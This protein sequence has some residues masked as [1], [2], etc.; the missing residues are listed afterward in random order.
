MQSLASALGRAVH[1]PGSLLAARRLEADPRA[2]FRPGAA[3]MLTLF[4]A[5]FAIVLTSSFDLRE[6]RKDR[7]DASASGVPESGGPDLFV[8]GSSSL[9]GPEGTRPA[10]V[11]QLANVRGVAEA[12]PVYASVYGDAIRDPSH[13]EVTVRFRQR[14]VVADCVDFARAVRAPAEDCRTGVLMANRTPPGL[15]LTLTFRAPDGQEF[16][17]TVPVS[18]RLPVLNDDQL[19]E[20]QGLNDWTTQLTGVAALVP[21]ALVPPEAR[22]RGEVTDVVLRTDGSVAT[23]RRVAGVLAAQAPGLDATAQIRRAR[24]DIDR[25]RDSVRPLLY[26]TLIFVLLVAVCSLIVNTIDSVFERRRPLATLRAVGASPATLRRAV[27]F[28]VAAPVL[29]AGAL[30]VVNGLVAGLLL[31]GV[32]DAPIVVPWIDLVA[33]S[34]LVCGAWVVVTA[35]AL[36]A[37]GRVTAA[38][39]LRTA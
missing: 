27:A 37:V 17:F 11:E 18:G 39:S 16:P 20:T 29:A 23:A 1:S 5:V 13:P 2:G 15:P 22:T 8:R 3:V 34:A 6:T 12:V 19:E 7:R 14:V 35:F 33:L 28:E 25:Y 4:V 10:I 9:I 30:G 38:E 32:L 24:I 21:P 26:G 36:G 31:V